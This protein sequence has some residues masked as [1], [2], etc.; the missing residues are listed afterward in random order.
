MT[1][2]HFYHYQIPQTMFQYNSNYLPFLGHYQIC[3]SYQFRIII[4]AGEGIHFTNLIDE[5]KNYNFISNT[6]NIRTI[7]LSADKLHRDGCINMERYEEIMVNSFLREVSEFINKTQIASK[8][9]ESNNI[10]TWPELEM[11]FNRKHE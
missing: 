7:L 10:T 8:D 1:Y 11:T 5:N 9:V 6:S 3:Q 4:I 2:T